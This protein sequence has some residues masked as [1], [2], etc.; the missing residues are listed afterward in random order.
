[1]ILPYNCE[2][3]QCQRRGRKKQDKR[4]EERKKNE[5]EKFSLSF[6]IF[7]D[8]ERFCSSITQ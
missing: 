6:C 5:S 3:D 7:R 2:Q 4:Q 1:M 8:G